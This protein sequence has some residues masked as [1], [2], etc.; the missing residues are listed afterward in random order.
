[1]LKKFISYFK[2]G[3]LNTSV[4]WII[5]LFLFHLTIPQSISNLVAFLIAMSLSF[6]LNAKYTFDKKATVKGYFLFAIFM[7]LL[8]YFCGY[9]GDI[10]KLNPIIT[11]VVF[12]GLS[13]VI[14]FLYSKLVVFK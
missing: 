8:S 1:M 6:V 12:S 10:L 13:L 3:I 4:H 7:A 9:I 2:I 5:F 11:L 14:G